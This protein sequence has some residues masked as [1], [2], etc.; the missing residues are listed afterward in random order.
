MTDKHYTHTCQVCKTE[1]PA[2]LNKDGTPRSRKYLAC[3]QACYKVAA[4]LSSGIKR[5]EHKMKD[6]AFCGKEFGPLSPRLYSKRN[7]CTKR[8]A[9]IKKNKDRGYNIYHKERHC[10]GC[11]APFT[12][13]VRP[14]K[15]SGTH[16][17]RECAHQ[18]KG[19]ISREVAFLRSMAARNR[20]PKVEQPSHVK[21]EVSALR[22]I[23][24]T[25]K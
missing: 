11:N 24:R 2:T 3:S 8:C 12:R 23:R 5:P 9:N 15:D 25:I 16:C 22:R 18:A 7:F 4:G 14:T 17:S 1:F 10:H 6:C 19:R 20:A 13:R 21:L